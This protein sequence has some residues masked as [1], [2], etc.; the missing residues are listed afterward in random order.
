MAVLVDITKFLYL[1]I[2][3]RSSQQRNQCKIAIVGT[4]ASGLACFYNAE[5]LVKVKYVFS[6]TL[7]NRFIYRSCHAEV[8]NDYEKILNDQEVK[9]VIICNSAK[10]HFEF[11]KKALLKKKHILVEKPL[12]LSLKECDELKLI[13]DANRVKIGGILQYRFLKALN[14]VKCLLDSGDLGEVIF[15][16]GKVYYKRGDDYFRYGRGTKNNDGGGV[17]IKQAI[18]CLDCMVYLGGGLI[19]AQTIL[20]NFRKDIDVEDSAVV[21]L[22]FSKG[23]G[24]LQATINSS[25]EEPFLIEVV[26]TKRKL[27]FDQK[28]RIISDQKSFLFWNLLA[29]IPQNLMYAQIKDFL[30]AV[31]NNQ[32]MK[33]DFSVARAAVANIKLLYA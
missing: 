30:A 4:G 7:R 3:R 11:A 17:L 22:K 15:I 31:E 1:S 28:N 29:F 25:Q 18:H 26:G 19:N 13:A 2:L 5:R 20:F 32:P 9:S 16:H 10:W 6:Q 8:I 14:K 33:V 21:L 12:C 24:S 27:S 23:N